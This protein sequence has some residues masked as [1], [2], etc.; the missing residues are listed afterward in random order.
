MSVPSA[1]TS[2]SERCC[3]SGRRCGRCGSRLTD[4]PLP[5][6]CSFSCSVRCSC[7]R[8]AARSTITPIAISIRTS[9]A[10]AI[11]RSPRARSRRGKRS[12]WAPRWPPGRGGGDGEL[13]ADAG[14][15]GSAGCAARAALAFLCGARCRG[16]DDALSLDADPQPQP[17][18]LLQ[19][20]PPRQLGR[21]RDLHR[22]R[23]EP[24]TGMNDESQ[25]ALVR[26]DFTSGAL[27]GSQ[28]MLYPRCLVHRSE[29][30]LETMP[31]ARV[32]ALKVSFER[33]PRRLGWGV[34]LVI[35]GLLLLSIS[36]PLGSFAHG[37]AQQMTAI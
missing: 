9:S 12:P 24:G 25:M 3:S 29:S 1:S 20:F 19:S 14:A 28:L 2:Q 4:G 27:R 6:S 35:V 7:D 23:R 17:R 10:R 21:W 26:F 13:C 5:A 37:P 31:L 30:H 15:A 36:W 34:A 8:P 18:G 33:E 16:R 22:H 32:T 11:A